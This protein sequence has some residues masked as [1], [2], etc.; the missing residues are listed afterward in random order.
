M[1]RGVN[2]SPGI[3]LPALP[4]LV[5]DG[6]GARIPDVR[7][8]HEGSVWGR[9]EQDLTRWFTLGLRFDYYTPDMSQSNNG[10]A[11]Y[12]AV[13]AVH[14]TRWLQYMVEY[15]HSVDNVHSAGGKPPNKVFDVLSNVL[16]VRF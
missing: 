1:D 16:Q 6:E 2:Y 12:A 8:L 13:A 4:A 14:F 3:G 9:V 11:T 5:I 7:N 10:R 15:N